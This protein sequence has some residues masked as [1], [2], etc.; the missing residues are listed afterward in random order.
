MIL[1]FNKKTL[2]DKKVEVEVFATT[3]EALNQT[4][5]G[6]LIFPNL[7]FW[8]R[9]IGALNRGALAIPDLKIIVES[10][11]SPQLAKQST[12][13]SGLTTLNKTA[14]TTPTVGTK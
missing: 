14:A 3:P 8:G 4:L 6:K 10:I 9:F 13:A 2:L 1:I 12:D 7:Q 11:P 5:V